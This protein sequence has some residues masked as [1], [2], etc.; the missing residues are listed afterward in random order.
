[1]GRDDTN[2]AGAPRVIRTIVTGVEPHAESLGTTAHQSIK[3]SVHVIQFRDLCSNSCR[4]IVE[5]HLGHLGTRLTGGGGV[6]L[7]HCPVTVSTP[8]RTLHS[9]G[10]GP[11]RG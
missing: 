4:E 9:V 10:R 3:T 8:A 5:H 6:Q 11:S 7:L 1:M 2:N